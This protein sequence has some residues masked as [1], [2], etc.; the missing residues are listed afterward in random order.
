MLLTQTA[1]KHGFI[2]F[3]TLNFIPF[4][5]KL[6]DVEMLSNVERNWLNEYHQKIFDKFANCL[7]EDDVTL[8]WLKENTRT[9]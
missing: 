1:E 5:C 9:L 3:E 7:S 2:E 6:I 8:N 4:S